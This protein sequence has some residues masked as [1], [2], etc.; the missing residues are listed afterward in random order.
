MIEENYIVT[1]AYYIFQNVLLIYMTRAPVFFF[2]WYKRYHL[3]KGGKSLPEYIPTNATA[4]FLG[5]TRV[6]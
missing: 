2:S 3:G 1:G 5:Y 4:H 6:L